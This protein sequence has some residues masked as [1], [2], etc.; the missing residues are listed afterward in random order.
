MESGQR[1]EGPRDPVL[2]GK[3]GSLITKWSQE[4]IP[5]HMHADFPMRVKLTSSQNFCPWPKG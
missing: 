5:T 1:G 2:F 3:L 4:L